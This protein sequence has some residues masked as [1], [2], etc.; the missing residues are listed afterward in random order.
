MSNDRI[1]VASVFGRL[2]T[3]GDESRLLN[4]AREV[5]RSRFDHFVI[6]CMAPTD[7]ERSRCERSMIET[8]RDEGIEVYDLGFD[9]RGIRTFPDYLRMLAQLRG[10]LRQRGVDVLDARMRLPTALGT[11]AAR[12][13]GVP[14]V[15]STGYY[16]EEWEGAALRVAGQLAFRGVDA[17]VSDAHH[18]VDRYQRWLRTRRPEFVVIPNGIQPAVSERPRAEVLT[19]LGLRDEPGTLV[20]QVSRLVRRKGFDVLLRAAPAVLAAQPDAQFLLCGHPEDAAYI[21]ELRVLAHDLGIADRVVITSYPGPIGDVL[22]VLDVF[23]HL[24]TDDSSPI[25]IHEAMSAGVAS[26]ISALPG[27]QELVAD[28][29]TGLLVRVADSAATATALVRLLADGRERARLGRAARA[30][31]EQR[32]TP[33]TMARRTE[34]LFERLVRGADDAESTLSVRTSAARLADGGAGGP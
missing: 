2:H 8:Y 1:C 6:V 11:L 17:F 19:S 7:A 14:V 34:A 18:T 22:S 24:S 27:N 15:V 32:H 13:S 28:G 30:R 3:A 4:F 12:T 31:F 5:D 23:T 10:I 26:V 25:A 9:P 20:G 21:E 16:P 29:E 33:A